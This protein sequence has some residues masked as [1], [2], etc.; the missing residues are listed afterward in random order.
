[1]HHVS[2]LTHNTVLNH[3]NATLRIIFV[4]SYWCKSVITKQR[5]VAPQVKRSSTIVI[6]WVIVNSKDN[7][8]HLSIYVPNGNMSTRTSLPSGTHP[9]KRRNITTTISKIC[10]IA[11]QLGVTMWTFLLFIYPPIHLYLTTITISWDHHIY[12]PFQYE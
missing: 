2:T 11:I 5:F 9:N 6:V 1:M 10:F 8:K 12:Y 7:S 4:V 3:T